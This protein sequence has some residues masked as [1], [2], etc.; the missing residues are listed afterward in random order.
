MVRVKQK[1]TAHK[2]ICLSVF[3]ALNRRDVNLLFS[4]FVFHTVIHNRLGDQSQI[5]FRYLHNHMDWRTMLACIFK[6]CPCQRHFP[7][8]LSGQPSLIPWV[9][10]DIVNFVL[11]QSGCG[12]GILI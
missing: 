8:A 11:S 3:P 9:D 4:V 1:V 6:D 2:H 10:G 5:T 7:S 12:G